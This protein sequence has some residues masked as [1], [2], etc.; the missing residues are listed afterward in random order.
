MTAA[1]TT[2]MSPPSAKIRSPRTARDR[3][4]PSPNYFS[5]LVPP[6]TAPSEPQ[7]DFEAFRRQSESNAFSLSHGSLSH[8]T[9]SSGSR[10]ASNEASPAGSR[11]REQRMQSPLSQ[12]RVTARPERG[13]QTTDAMDIDPPSSSQPSQS[14]VQSPN[15]S[16]LPPSSADT[17]S[18]LDI[19]R[20]LSPSSASTSELSSLRRSQISKVDE[21]HPRNSLPQNRIDPPSPSSKNQDL[22]RAKTLPGSLHPDSPSLISPQELCDIRQSYLPDDILLLDV[23]VFPQYSQSRV[24]GAL[25]LCIPTTL[26]KRP[27][28]NAQKLADTFTKEKEK[29]KFDRWQEAKVIVVYDTS[30]VLL[31]DATSSV[32]TLKKFTAEGWRGSACILRGG[33]QAV[34]NK[35]PDLVDRRPANEMETAQGRKLTID[36]QRPLVAPVAGGCLMPSDQTAA[37]PFFGTIRQNMDLIGGVGQMPIK[38]PARLRKSRSKFLPLWLRQASSEE[39][40]GKKVADRFLRIEQGEQQRMQKALTSTVHYG[41]PDHVSPNAVKIA[42]IEKGTKNRY[43]DM[44]P[45]DHSRVRLQNVLPGECDYINASHIKSSLSQRHYIASQAPVPATI[46]DF[47]RVVWE[48][49]VQV[50]V[51]LTAEH[52]GGQRKS[53][54]YWNGSYGSYV[55]AVHG[56]NEIP[57]DSSGHDNDAAAKVLIRS[58][59]VS[60]SGLSREITQVHYSNWPDVGVPTDPA[61]LLGVLKICSGA[62]QSHHQ[63][64][65]DGFHPS[66]GGEEQPVLVHCSAGCG[67]TGTFCVVDSVLATLQAHQQKF[68]DGGGGQSSSSLIDFSNDDTTDDLIALTVED[69]RLQRLSMVQTLRQFV[70]CYET[71]LQW[72]DMRLQSMGI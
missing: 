58:I 70:L 55:A 30:S 14:A 24:D 29:A 52:D 9:A 34:S 65:R 7:A 13:T 32:N 33:F 22:H 27:A 42:G 28:F 16:S 48:Q 61:H 12:T 51:M 21:K 10:N 11:E 60:R 66:H 15:S 5:S 72:F 3:G 50:I 59:T 38:I 54:P 1:T 23:R 53:H 8:F 4:A 35:F 39:N 56:M 2:H 19:P 71:V 25:N 47:W 45:Y 67:R 64:L 69:F 46:E 41:T 40:A 49:G 68:A 6:A 17:P 26:L 31:K 63:N 57:L 43:K 18:F 37:N 62:V 20:K 44:L 36:P